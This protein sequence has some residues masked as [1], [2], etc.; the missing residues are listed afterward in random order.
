[1]KFAEG[2]GTLYLIDTSVLARTRI[3]S[4]QKVV[5]GLILEHV[6]ATCVTIDLEVGF[7]GR[8]QAEVVAQ[9]R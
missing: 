4:V 9:S 3:P 2:H 6:A 1:M 5:A 7:S 8:N